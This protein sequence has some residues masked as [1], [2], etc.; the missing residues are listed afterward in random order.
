MISAMQTADDFYFD[1]VMQIHMPK[2]SA[3]RVAVLGDAAP[4]Y[5]M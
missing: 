2:W 1:A 3:G 4:L 5:G